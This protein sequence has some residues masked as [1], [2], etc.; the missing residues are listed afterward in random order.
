L[1][2]LCKA[3][4]LYTVVRSPLCEARSSE[5]GRYD[6]DTSGSVILAE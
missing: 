4:I 3:G 5:L 2:L 1:Q 6:I